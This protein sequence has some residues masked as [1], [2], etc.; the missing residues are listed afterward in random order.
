[1]GLNDQAPTVRIDQGMTLAT[2]DL[3]RGIEASGSARFNGF[4][5]LAVQN[6][7]GRTNSLS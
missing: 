6:G 3:F 4:G 1:M 2:L 7:G 5:A